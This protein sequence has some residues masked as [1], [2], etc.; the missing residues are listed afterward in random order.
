MIAS[1]SSPVRPSG[2]I[3]QKNTK[4]DGTQNTIHNLAATVTLLDNSVKKRPVQLSGIKE[5][6]NYLIV[7]LCAV[8]TLVS[9]VDLRSTSDTLLR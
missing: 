7:M 2:E 4:R 8:R 9:I 1:L 3:G 6:S 5:H